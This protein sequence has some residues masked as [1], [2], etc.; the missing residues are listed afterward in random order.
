MERE[1]VRLETL[2]EV[3]DIPL[4]TLRKWA[5]KWAF[6]GIRSTP[7]RRIY[8]D[9]AKFRERWMSGEGSELEGASNVCKGKSSY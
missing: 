7:G 1:T 4:W 9:L 3:F 5:S 6:P 2:S 8:V